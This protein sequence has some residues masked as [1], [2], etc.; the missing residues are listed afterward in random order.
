MQSYI[1]GIDP[2][3]IARPGPVIAVPRTVLNRTGVGLTARSLRLSVSVAM[4][5]TSYT[6]QPT[7]ITCTETETDNRE[8]K[9]TTYLWCGNLCCGRGCVSGMLR[10][11]SLS[12]S[13]SELSNQFAVGRR[14]QPAVC[15]RWCAAAAAAL[16]A[17]FHALRFRQ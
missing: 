2:N 14:R 15:C 9:H 1:R 12:L 17:F 16:G 5:S 8:Q 6:T 7:S 11:L 3:A 10:L 13:H 4:Y